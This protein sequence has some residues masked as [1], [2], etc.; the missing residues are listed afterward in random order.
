[1][2]YLFDNCLEDAGQ[3]I[4]TLANDLGIFLNSIKYDNGAQVPQID[5][6]G[7]SIGGLIA[8]AYLAG[9]QL[10]ATLTPPNPTL[11]RDL[12]LI[13]TPNFGSFLAG[14]YATV[15]GAG[16]QSAELEPG[17]SF[18]WNLGTWNQLGDDLRGV[19]AIAVI[20]N[21]GTYTPN[22]SSTESLADASDG[23]VSL[24]SASLGFVGQQAEVT[25]IVPYC[26][27]DPG[28]FT[29][30]AF[31]TFACNAGG[32]AN[33]T[34]DTQY[35]GLIVRS[36]L[37]GTTDWQSIGSTPATDPY[38]SKDGALFFAMVNAAGIY[39][40]DLTGVTFG[41]VPLVNGGDTGTI[42]YVDF[43]AGT[44]ALSAV[45]QSLGT[46]NCGSLPLALGFTSV[47]LCKLDTAIISVGPLTGTGGRTVS[48]GSAITIT[49][50]DFGS[51][52]NGCK[53]VAS[54]AGS[55]TGQQLTIS[56]WSST[57]IKA[58]LPASLTGLVTIEVIAAA[59]I[60]SIAVMIIPQS[61]LTVTPTSLQFTYTTGA[62]AP[63][64]QSIQITN[65]GSGTL[66]WSA[67]A[68]ATWISVSSTS[69]TAPSTL[70][71]SISTA[72]LSA[73]TYTGSIQITAANASNSPAS[74]GVTLTVAALAPSLVVAPQTLSF[75]YT[76]SGAA[77][78][79]QS[80]AITNAGG[81]GRWPG[82]LRPM[83]IG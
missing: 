26:H 53:V 47:E 18:L 50:V 56:S 46:I 24:T 30:T 9:L 33:V 63:G 7:F 23:L 78:A 58:N 49:G 57:S 81:G 34:S 13:A 38:L 52:C 25:R 2:V 35:T 16:T 29:N 55:S 67:T 60:D 31:G 20:G 54:P 71:V 40:A 10:N 70:S 32:I 37:A 73:G 4:E 59:G 28:T 11:V 21:A 77:P 36:F 65:S 75:Q 80:V 83:R 41:T 79:S 51:Q 69:G 5:L 19:S 82:R 22:L 76:Y 44:G 15:I 61:S 66:S 68:S 14:N 62:S 8:R 3:P 45:S 74:I 43:V 48:A 72:G 39:V 27:V 1:M 64:S 6:V 17:S 42:F 12:V